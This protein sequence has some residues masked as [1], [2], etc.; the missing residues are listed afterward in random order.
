MVIRQIPQKAG[1]KFMGR[2]SDSP[3]NPEKGRAGMRKTNIQIVRDM[4]Q[5][6][7]TNAR[8]HVHG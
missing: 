4:R 1:V 7:T 5:P 6:A 8:V 2:E 3:T